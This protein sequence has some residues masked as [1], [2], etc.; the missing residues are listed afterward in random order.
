MIRICSVN[1]SQ[2]N[3]D[4][5]LI[6]NIKIGR[7]DE[8]GFTVVGLML[9]EKNNEVI[10]NQ[11]REFNT[12]YYEGDSSK[13]ERYLRYYRVK[14]I[15]IGI[16]LNNIKT[17][18]Q[19]KKYIKMLRKIGKI[20]RRCKTQIGVKDP[21]GEYYPAIIFNYREELNIKNI[22]IEDLIES[23]KLEMYKTKKERYEYI[24]DKTCSMLDYEFISKNLCEFKDNRCLDK[25]RSNVICGCCRYYKNLF[26]R[27]F[28][29]C[30][31]LKNKRCQAKCITCK[32]FTCK[33]LQE[34]GI[35]FKMKDFYF[36]NYYFN[37]PQKLVVKT[38]YFKT[39]DSI[40]HKLMKLG[41]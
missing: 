17:E 38:S 27:E 3:Y 15:I 16:N 20:C 1:Y 32:F 25:Y 9:N 28:I 18:K 21:N 24:Y 35:V 23:V 5:K 4:I 37:I 14:S 34:K 40:I 30:K 29:K 39:R 22:K 41:K 6:H 7:L 36:I 26:S 11:L 2:D 8:S 33:T 19:V 10:S 31:Y 12:Y 13:F